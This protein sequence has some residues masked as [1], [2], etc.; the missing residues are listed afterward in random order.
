MTHR[1]RARTVGVRPAPPTLWLGVT[2]KQADVL[3]SRLKW[4]P[5]TTIFTSATLESG[6]LGSSYGDNLRMCQSYLIIVA[7]QTARRIV[8]ELSIY[9]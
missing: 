4:Q 1:T 7:G 2:I 5:I 6:F 9:Q 3:L 8:I